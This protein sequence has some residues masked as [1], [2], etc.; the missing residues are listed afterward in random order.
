M[1]FDFNK[2]F[3]TTIGVNHR[4]FEAGDIFKQDR[5]KQADEMRY[6]RYL[7]NP[8][9][10]S[11]KAFF[12]VQALVKNCFDDLILKYLFGTKTKE[13]YDEAC[14]YLDQILN[15]AFNFHIFRTLKLNL[16]IYINMYA[17]QLAYMMHKMNILKIDIAIFLEAMKAQSIEPYINNAKQAIS[18]KTNKDLAIDLSYKHDEFIEL[19]NQKGVYLIESVGP[20]SYEKK[21]S[22]WKKGKELPSLFEMLLLSRCISSKLSSDQAKRAI[23][24]QLLLTRALLSCKSVYRVQE[25]DV[26]FFN[27]KF[28]D[29]LHKIPLLEDKNLYTLKSNYVVDIANI[30]S[31]DLSLDEKHKILQKDFIKFTNNNLLDFTIER[32]P[33][34]DRILQKFNDAKFEEVIEELEIKSEPSN[35]LLDVQRYFVLALASIKIKDQKRIRKYIKLCDVYMFSGSL[36]LN[37]INPS[38]KNYCAVLENSQTFKECSKV[39]CEYLDH[40]KKLSTFE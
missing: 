14:F 3:W 9:E 15:I 21:I 35:I 32:F 27:E 31:L 5:D 6:D 29:F 25:K 12:E 34:A 40:Q 26:L 30:H 10:L 24:M 20:S 11:S 17:F 1:N 33:N 22:E 19:I 16:E 18:V 13:I 2:E 28:Y 36:L 7:D 38:I 23:L 37:G 39:L 4:V 8:E